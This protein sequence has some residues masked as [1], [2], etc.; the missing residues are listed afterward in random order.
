MER[1]TKITPSNRSASKLKKNIPLE[2]DTLIH[3]WYTNNHCRKLISC[4]RILLI[5]RGTKFSKRTKKAHKSLKHLG[6]IVSSIE[7]CTFVVHSN[8]SPWH[9]QLLNCFKY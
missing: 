4:T 5:S 3:L 7:Y 1:L 9:Q 6:S 2:H 8:K